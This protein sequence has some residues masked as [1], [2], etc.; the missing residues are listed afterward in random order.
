MHAADPLAL[1]PARTQKGS[2]VSPL[3]VLVDA[4]LAIDA[5]NATKAEGDLDA[6]FVPEL[7]DA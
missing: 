4:R 5:L 2:R 1:A 3:S 7:L 6:L